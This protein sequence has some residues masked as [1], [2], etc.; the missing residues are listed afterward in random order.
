MA[1]LVLGIISLLAWFIPLCGLPVSVTG[2]VLSALG[3]R[4]PTARGMATAGLVLSII[5]VV[6]SIINAV[7]GAY[8]GVRGEL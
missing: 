8:L 7:L 5:G 4:D 6:A 2:I 3:R 1:G